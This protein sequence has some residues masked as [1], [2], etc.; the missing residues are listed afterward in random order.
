MNES[1]LWSHD[2][3]CVGSA[4]LRQEV[5]LLGLDT[6]QRLQCPQDYCY[7]NNAPCWKIKSTNRHMWTQLLGRSVFSL[8]TSCT[9]LRGVGQR[10]TKEPIWGL[11]CAVRNTSGTWDRT[12]LG[13][14]P[15]TGCC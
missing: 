11:L 2:P 10:V 12:R 15:K 1:W 8:R 3:I 13:F 5:L 6:Q 7:Q 9:G 4:N 14:H